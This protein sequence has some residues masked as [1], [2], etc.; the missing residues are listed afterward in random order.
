M[1]FAHIA[2]IHLGYEQYNQP[3]RAED[4]AK[5]LQNHC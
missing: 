2:D 3:W 4:F 1:K 5:A